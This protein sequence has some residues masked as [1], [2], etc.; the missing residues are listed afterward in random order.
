MKFRYPLQKIVDLKESEK[1]QAEWSLSKALGE[2]R[3]E[4]RTLDEWKNERMKWEQTIHQMCERGAPVAE[5]L[6]IEK[7]LDYVDGR[8]SAQLL[9]VELAKDRVDARK[10]KLKSKMIDEKIWKTTMEKA[11]M[12]FLQENGRKEQNELDDLASV[13]FART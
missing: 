3:Q 2:L 4:E 9:Q 5:L 1:T 11:K 8:I 12:Q 6:A 10:K 7:H 13:R